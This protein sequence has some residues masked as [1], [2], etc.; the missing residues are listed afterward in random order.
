MIYILKAKERG[1]K[2]P[3]LLRLSQVYGVKRWTRIRLR[4][5][6]P[7]P[8]VRILIVE[9]RRTPEGVEKQIVV[10]ASSFP[11]R[12]PFK[13]SLLDVVALGRKR[14]GIIERNHD[15]GRLVVNVRL[16]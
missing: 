4:V 5:P 12:K 13:T 2:C 15:F 16:K 1:G 9:T 7:V 14:L 11:H 10:I 3:N 6:V 8:L